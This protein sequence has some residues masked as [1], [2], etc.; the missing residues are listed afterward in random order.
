M[1]ILT[2]QGT[3][4][5]SALLE[6][7]CNML[8]ITHIQCTPYHPEG[9][10]SL[11]RAHGKL[12]EY[13]QYYTK[14]ARKGEWDETLHLAMSAYNKSKHG[15]T[16]FTPH[17]LVFGKMPNLPTKPIDSESYAEYKFLLEDKL[18]FLHACAKQ[19]I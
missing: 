13:L 14:V 11:E 9:N 10:G 17:E 19:N 4:F 16:G 12:K 1:V 15:S 8:N 2:N 3:E 6:L 7:F 18:Q 5:T